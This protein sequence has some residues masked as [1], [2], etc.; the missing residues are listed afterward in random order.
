MNIK[1]RLSTYRYRLPY[2]IAFACLGVSF[3]ASRVEAQTWE[4][5]LTLSEENLCTVNGQ[6]AGIPISVNPGDEVIVQV[7]NNTSARQLLRWRGVIYHG[8]PGITATTQAASR[9]FYSLQ[10]PVGTGETFTY[11]WK[12]ESKGTLVYDCYVAIEQAI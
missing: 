9:R 5:K 4:F 12:M 10:K 7:R 1:A 11:R 2:F 6:S 3:F 8:E